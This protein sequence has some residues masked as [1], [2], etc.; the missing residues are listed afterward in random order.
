M[1]GVGLVLIWLLL[2]TVALWLER[3]LAWRDVPVRHVPLVLRGIHQFILQLLLHGLLR[4]TGVL[5]RTMVVVH[6]CGLDFTRD[7]LVYTDLITP[8]YL[9]DMG[10]HSNL[11]TDSVTYLNQKERNYGSVIPNSHQILLFRL[12]H[13]FFIKMEDSDLV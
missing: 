11:G 10:P 1:A 8:A 6:G 4:G 13:R 2:D 12:V 3:V 9:V 5:L 7:N